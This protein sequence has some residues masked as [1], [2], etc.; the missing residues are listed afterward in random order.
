MV[1]RVEQSPRFEGALFETLDYLTS[2]LRSDSAAQNFV[3]EV[4]LLQELLAATLFIKAVSQ[5]PFLAKRNLR[6]YY[7]S[8]YVVL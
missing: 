8:N 2:K 7:L 3:E 4:D 6:E 5:K 1:Y